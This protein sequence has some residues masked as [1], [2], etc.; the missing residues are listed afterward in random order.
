MQADPMTLV[1][2]VCARLCHDLGG[3]A[4]ALGGALELLDGVGDDALDVARDAARIMDRR[5]R[6]WRAAV[7]GTLGELHEDGLPP[8]LEG[9]TLGRRATVST[10][11]LAF[12]APLAPGFG[13][14]LLLAAWAGIEALPRG[15]VLRL[16]GEA[17]GGVTLLPD[18]PGAAWPHGLPAALTGEVPAPEPRGVVVP[19]LLDAASRAGFGLSLLPAPPEGAPPLLLLP[20]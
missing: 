14:C 4:G 20:G 19:L 1:Q 12:R 18:G 17:E 10:E 7:A 13:Q 9:L 6:F 3:P 2:A 8:L 16:A 11:A 5:L 15:G